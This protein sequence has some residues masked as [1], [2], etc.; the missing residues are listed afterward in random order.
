ME[1]KH[2]TTSWLSIN[3][4]HCKNTSNTGIALDAVKYI[5]QNK[6]EKKNHFDRKRQERNITQSM[7]INIKSLLATESI[8]NEKG[9]QEHASEVM[10]KFFFYYFKKSK[11]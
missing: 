8:V 4:N 11:K 1:R 10:G 2:I 7:L 5:Y 9:K 3:H 6:K